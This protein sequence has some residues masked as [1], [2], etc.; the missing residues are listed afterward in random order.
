[1]HWIQVNRRGRLMGEMEIGT[2][3]ETTTAGFGGLRLQWSRFPPASA[4]RVSGAPVPP[5]LHLRLQCSPRSQTAM[6][7]DGWCI[8]GLQWMVKRCMKDEGLGGFTG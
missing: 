7:K 4:T 8:D 1:M 5:D 6:S 3:S 2:W